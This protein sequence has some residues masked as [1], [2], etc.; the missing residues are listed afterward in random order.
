MFALG[1]S[2]NGEEFSATQRK[3][4]RARC[5]YMFHGIKDLALEADGEP[6]ELGTFSAREGHDNLRALLAE[7]EDHSCFEVKTLS[8]I[9]AMLHPGMRKKFPAIRDI[10]RTFIVTLTQYV[11]ASLDV[12]RFVF[13]LRRSRGG[14]VRQVTHST[15]DNDRMRLGQ[16]A[17]PKFQC[18]FGFTGATS[19]FA[20]AAASKKL[21]HQFNIAM[22]VATSREF[23]QF[24]SEKLLPFVVRTCV[25][26]PDSYGVNDELMS[27][28]Q[29]DAW[30]KDK[31]SLG[32]NP[33][34]R[35]MAQA[36]KDGTE[37]PV[38]GAKAK[39]FFAVP[40]ML[41]RLA[42]YGIDEETQR[43]AKQLVHEHFD[44]QK[45]GA[46][47]VDVIYLAFFEDLGV[48]SKM[49]GGGQLGRRCS[50]RRRSTCRS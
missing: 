47:R 9:R 46:P 11:D 4:Y 25:Q 37:P 35:L 39:V 36:L 13:C 42:L 7:R 21:K 32:N 6:P 48:S 27:E 14:G 5:S 17:K 22:L 3:G 20:N 33:T 50:T 2:P 43:K 45:I 8:F 49:G 12:L 24:L 30:K 18:L 23:E 26:F 1:V 34:V 15:Q 31:K 28:N 44:R 10:V 19:K 38:V 16:K 29:K 40:K 41:K